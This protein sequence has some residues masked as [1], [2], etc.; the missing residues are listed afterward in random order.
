MLNV[1]ISKD[2]NKVKVIASGNGAE[3]CSDLTQVF[4]AL[5]DGMKEQDEKAAEV[6]K[7]TFLAGFD[8]GIIFNCTSEEM[9]KMRETARKAIEKKSDGFIDFLLD[10]LNELN[11]YLE[12]LD[13]TK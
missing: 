2:S 4:H 11:K 13:E 10:K 5:I 3:I 1:D 12:G 7:L 6:F 9:T 8:S